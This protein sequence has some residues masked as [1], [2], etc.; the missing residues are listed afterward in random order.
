MCVFVCVYKKKSFLITHYTYTTLPTPQSLHIFRS[1]SA[2][3]WRNATSYRV[4]GQWKD[5]GEDPFI[6]R[7]LT[8]GVYHALIHVGRPNT[9]GLHYFSETGGSWSAS[10]SHGAAYTA[11]GL[12]C[13]ERPHVVLSSEGKV[14]ALTNGAAKVACHQAGADDH[15]VTL[16]QRM[17]TGEMFL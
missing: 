9:T 1:F 2:S 14:I 12:A 17:R 13:R 10:P 16:L 8:D 5:E 6:W 7:N 3:D 11:M 4:V 15:S